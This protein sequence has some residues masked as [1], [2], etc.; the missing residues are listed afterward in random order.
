MRSVANKISLVISAAMIIG[1]VVF[2]Y[3]LSSKTREDVSEI[4]ET[5]KS[6]VLS[7]ASNYVD[8]FVVKC[9]DDTIALAKQFEKFGIH[10]EEGMGS[11]MMAIRPN[12]A[13][14]GIY[15][16]YGSDGRFL[17]SD[18]SSSK[19]IY[20]TPATTGYDSRSRGWYKEAMG[21]NPGITSPYKDA[22]TGEMVITFFYPYKE[23]G[24]VTAVF[25]S[26]LSLEPIQ[27]FL[28]RVQIGDSQVLV[29][30]KAAVTIAHSDPTRITSDDAAYNETVKSIFAQAKAYPGK[31]VFYEFGG[32][33]KAANCSI[34]EKTG[35]M[36][37]ITSSLESIEKRATSSLIYQAVISVIFIVVIVALLVFIVT[38]GLKPLKTI[39]SGLQGF[40]DF[41]NHKTNDAQPIEINSQDEFGTTAKAINENIRITKENLAKDNDAISETISI[42]NAVESGDLSR[43]IRENPANP[44]IVRLK[45]V[46]NGMLGALREKIGADTNELERVFNS[47]GNSNFTTSV[48][49]DKGK[50]GEIVNDLGGEIRSMLNRN[51]SNAKALE[52]QAKALKE[53]VVNLNDGAR[54]QAH[55]LEE[56]AAA[57][58]EMS[59]SMGS[60]GERSKEVIKQSDDIKSIVSIIQDIADQ[61]NLLALNAA[62]EAARAGESGRGFAVVADEV[63]KLADKIQKSLTEISAN[64]NILVQGINEISESIGEQTVAINQIN[65]ATLNVNNLTKQNVEI[66]DKTNEITSVVDEMARSM[67]TDVEKNKF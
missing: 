66:A 63:R 44:D 10:N 65:E 7:A 56:A 47:Y 30:D 43:S 6:E 59:S 39:E 55:S 49:G 29:A 42:A 53:Y 50:F 28:S 21:G 20:R 14:M 17:G 41:V 34:G 1:F 62:I 61:T 52:E 19:L 45:D 2:S 26:D 3:V 24:A 40:F 38:L 11:L 5:G 15:V 4:F 16:G 35:W 54:S 37:C 46:F 48:E 12:T 31:T 13:F 18:V 25:G 36:T 27:K 22:S 67:V 8:Y 32:I 64:V 33:A 58:D 9:L 60:I 23:N 57:V 51:L